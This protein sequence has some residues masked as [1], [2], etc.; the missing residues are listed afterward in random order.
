VQEELADTVEL[1]V[2]APAVCVKPEPEK[3]MV[4]P[5]KPEVELNVTVCPP[6]VNDSDAVGNPVVSMKVTVYVPAAIFATTKLPLIEPPAVWVHE[7]LAETVELTV[8]APAVWEKPEP[9][10]VTVAPTRPELELMV[11]VGPI[12]VSEAKAEGNA[13]LSVKV[14]EYGPA[15][16]SA[17]MKLPPIVPLDVWVQV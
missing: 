1:T 7:E 15:A 3:V 5:M 2:Q 11:T 10:K 8:Q 14:M 9:E 13:V 16:T 6:T 17:I 4:E 12:T